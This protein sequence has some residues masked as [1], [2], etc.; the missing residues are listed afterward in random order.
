MAASMRSGYTTGTCAA[1]AAKAATMIL[2]G[3]PAPEYV[4]VA[5][6]DGS[7]ARLA[8]AQSDA[9]A[10]SVRAAVKKDAGDDPDI[11]DGVLV[12]STVSWVRGRDVLLAAGDGVGTV[13]RPGLAVPPGEP[14]INP[15]PQ[16]M[17]RAAVR[18]VTDR[19]VQV[20]VSIPGGKELAEKTFNPRLGIVGGLSILGT[21]G[22][23]RPFSS[24][25]LRDSLKCALDVAKAL[26]VK[27][28]VLVPGR[29]GERAANGHFQLSD[30]QLIEVSNEWGFMLD[31]ASDIPFDDM[32]VLGHPGKLA[33]LAGGQWD[34]HSKRSSSAV[35]LV[36]DLATRLFGRSIEETV[37]VEG[38]LMGLELQE[39]TILANELASLIR[40]AVS[41]RVKERFHVAV[42]LVN[43]KGD[44]LG[45]HGDM[46]PW[47][48]R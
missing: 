46:Q 7:R 1:A 14:A 43:L 39:R 35:P 31:L 13:T 36:A 8:I 45:L 37:T 4:E 16:S 32:L 48:I 19:G 10:D 40:E 17:I 22:I 12:W 21:S 15:V 47:P 23:V 5:L 41:Q 18:E 33:K 20:V 2:A 44:I 3:Q 29:I 42:V 38:F 26:H 11:T 24:S 6:P 27:T 25:A 30:E 34:T 28:P 9:E